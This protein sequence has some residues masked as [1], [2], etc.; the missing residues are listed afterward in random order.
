MRREDLQNAIPGWLLRIA[1]GSNTDARAHTP[2][3]TRGLSRFGGRHCTEAVGIGQ[4]P[5]YLTWEPAAPKPCTD[6]CIHKVRSLPLHTRSAFSA[7]W[8]TCHNILTE[9]SEIGKW[10]LYY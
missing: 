10:Q 2:T 7:F 1:C 4:V 8:T 5:W 3:K 6:G 9:T